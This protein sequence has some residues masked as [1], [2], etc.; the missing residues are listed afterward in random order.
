MWTALLLALAAEMTGRTAGG[1][2]QTNVAVVYHT[3]SGHTMK[4]AE[5]IAGGAR[6]AGATVRLLPC[7]NATY[8]NETHPGDVLWADAV[9]VGSPTHYGN[10]AAQILA[11]FESEW[12][13][14]FYDTA[15]NGK[16]GSVFA[17]GGG[18]NQGVSHVITGLQRVLESFRIQYVAPDPSRSGYHSY[19]AVAITGTEPFNN[20]CSSDFCGG[21]AIAPVFA[22]A[23]AQLGAKVVAAAQTRATMDRNL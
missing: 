11:W 6:K 20:T 8:G 19:G 15:L 10:P 1:A 7:A 23:G 17:T 21:S 4:L 12:E 5:A 18:V 16:V 13:H 3:E 2:P 22:E 14:G 9:I